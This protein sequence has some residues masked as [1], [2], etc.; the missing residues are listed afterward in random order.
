ME[1]ALSKMR[2]EGVW[3][4]TSLLIQVGKVGVVGLSFVKKADQRRVCLH[5]GLLHKRVFIVP[6]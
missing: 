2:N 3:V 6:G 4:H 5:V 1:T